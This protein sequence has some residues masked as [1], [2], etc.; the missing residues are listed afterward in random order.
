MIADLKVVC[1]F[2][3]SDL[4]MV[5]QLGGAEIVHKQQATGLEPAGD[6]AQE[7]L[8]VLH[9]LEHLDAD[10]AVVGALCA[11]EL[12]HVGGDDLQVADAAL[13]RT[14]HDEL[15]LRPAV[16]NRRHLGQSQPG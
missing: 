4:K 13:G 1:D 7:L 10:H 15:V 2:M 8:V 6:A 14:R 12:R 11:L 3:I 16:R 9:V 5:R